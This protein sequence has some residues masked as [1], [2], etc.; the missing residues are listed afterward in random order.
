MKT[1]YIFF[2]AILLIILLFTRENG[3]AQK[4]IKQNDFTVFSTNAGAN[5]VPIEIIFKKGIQHYFPLMA[6]WVEDTTGNY[7]HPLYV[8][9]SIAKGKFKH[10]KYQKGKWHKDKKIIPAALPYWGHR[11]T[12]V[13]HDSIFMPTPE[14]P[15]PDAYTG[16]TPT[17]SFVLKTAVDAEAGQVFNILFEINQSWDWNQYWYNGRYPG[18]KEYLKSAQPALVYRV[19]INANKHREKYEM[20]PVGHSHPYGA[21]GNLYKDLSTLTT[22][23]NIAD[24]IVVKVK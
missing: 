6:I 2:T 23:L 22:A 9:E 15:L 1:K 17:K 14:H 24:K 3:Y 13:V 19:T 11:Q 18:N 5:G 7:I 20:K 10:A 8:A 21:D 16:A 4:Q 12:D